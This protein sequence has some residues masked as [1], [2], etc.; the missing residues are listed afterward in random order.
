MQPTSI[1]LAFATALFVSTPAL[2]SDFDGSKPL[3][4][5]PVEAMDCTPGVECLKGTPDDI[6][7]PAFMRID[8]AKKTVAGPKRTSPIQAMENVED[9][10]LLRGTELG[11]G[12][13]MVLD[14]ANGKMSAT[15][16]DRH[17]AFVIFGSCTPL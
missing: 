4:C 8:F 2:A 11:Y 14:H 9:Q 17:G 16:T 3:I 13:I 15:L 5:A 10:L 1:G 12:W 6:G 7:A